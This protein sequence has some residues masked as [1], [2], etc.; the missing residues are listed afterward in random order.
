MDAEGFEGLLVVSRKTKGRTLIGF[1]FGYQIMYEAR[2]ERL[3]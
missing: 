3:F 2:E 1:G